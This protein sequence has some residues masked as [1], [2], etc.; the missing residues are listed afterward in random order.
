VVSELPSFSAKITLWL[1]VL[2]EKIDLNK[3]PE[4]I[5][6]IFEKIEHLEIIIQNLNI[7]EKSEK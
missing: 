4:I 2:M 6:Q 5:C 3:L 7:I 1:N